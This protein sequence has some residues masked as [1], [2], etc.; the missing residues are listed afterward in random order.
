MTRHVTDA[1]DK[2]YSVGVNAVMEGVT[3][4]GMAVPASYQRP[5]MALS[6]SAI[7]SRIP[8]ERIPALVEQL[9]RSAARIAAITGS[10]AAAR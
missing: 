7:S 2:G 8:P 6:V 1:R 5:F 10:D 3:A 9:K 4:V